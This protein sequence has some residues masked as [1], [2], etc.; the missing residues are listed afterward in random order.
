MHREEGKSAAS[1]LGFSYDQVKRFAVPLATLVA[2]GLIV[3]LLFQNRAELRSFH[4]ELDYA[5]ALWSFVLCVTT[6]LIMGIN[7]N[8]ITRRL[9][10]ELD[11]IDSMHTYYISSVAQFVPGRIWYVVS[12]LYLYTQ[13]GMKKAVTSLALIFEMCTLVISGIIVYII[14]ALVFPSPWLTP[15]RS[16]GLIFIMVLALLVAYPPLLIGVVNFLLNLLGKSR[17][18]SDVRYRDILTWIGVHVFNWLIGGMVL[19]YLLASLGP[20][21]GADF[22]AVLQSFCIS[23]VAT[24]LLFF[25]PAGFGTR[26]IALIYLLSAVA[27]SPL[28][29]VGTLLFR[30]WLIASEFFCAIL[31][32]IYRRL[33]S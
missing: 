11:P 21:S 7:W 30:I 28:V 32:D 33:R 24:Q 27:P 9:G 16:W 14:V 17:I 1:P 12:R 10:S 25:I 8:L 31:L 13:E 15:A 19:Y 26:E 6:W 2:F 23:G 22:P 4:W 5:S 18:V 3:V 20:L 29:L